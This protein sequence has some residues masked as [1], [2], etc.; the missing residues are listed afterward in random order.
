MKKLSVLIFI[1]ALGMGAYHFKT[2]FYSPVSLIPQEE[3]VLTWGHD[4]SKITLS[5]PT[6]FTFNLKDH[7]QNF[8]NDAQID[9]EATMDHAGMVPLFSKA[10]QKSE[11]HYETN[12]QVTMLGDWLLFLTITLPGHKPIKKVLKFQASL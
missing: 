1:A 10:T 6:K 11:G 2:R 3:I 4:P 9:V 7:R 5:A 8:I 12:L